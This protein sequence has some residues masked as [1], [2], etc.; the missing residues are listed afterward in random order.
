MANVLIPDTLFGL[1]CK[2]HLLG[3]TDNDTKQAIENALETKLEALAAHAE[4]SKYKTS[5]SPDERE[6]ARKAYLDRIELQD[7]YRW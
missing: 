3:I 4:Y 5:N 6:A 2:Y 1:L 7:N